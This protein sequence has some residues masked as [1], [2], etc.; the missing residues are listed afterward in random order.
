MTTATLEKRVKALEEKVKSL[1][2]AKAARAKL[3]KMV[4][5]GLD[6]GLG[7]PMDAAFWKKMRMHAGRR[8][9]K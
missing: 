1:D 5:D 7:K 2:A 9:R 3:R 4:L 8:T 6:S